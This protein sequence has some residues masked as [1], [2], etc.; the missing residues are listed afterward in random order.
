VKKRVK[1]EAA[2][3][4]ESGTCPTFKDTQL[5]MGESDGRRARRIG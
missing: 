1:V 2:A 4:N 3:G 5:E